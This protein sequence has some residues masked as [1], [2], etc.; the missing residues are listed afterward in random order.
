[1]AFPD[2]PAPFGPNY[3]SPPCPLGDLSHTR[4]HQ[5]ALHLDVAVC[6]FLKVTEHTSI[7]ACTI[8]QTFLIHR[9][10]YSSW[11]LCSAT[12]IDRGNGQ[13]YAWSPSDVYYQL[14]WE[15]FLQWLCKNL[16]MKI[17]F[18]LDALVSF[19]GTRSRV[20]WCALPVR[21]NKSWQD[22]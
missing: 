11:S 5:G 3:L 14:I 20:L 19:G 7:N 6:R 2:A 21:L 8:T 4:Q 10:P 22:N 18:A 12:S 15:T 1:M 17:K 16:C 13:S 9:P